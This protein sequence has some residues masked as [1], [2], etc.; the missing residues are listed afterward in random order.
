M[1]SG[2]SKISARLIAAL[3][4]MTVL[5]GGA[6]VYIGIN[7]GPVIAA[8][9]TIA[10]AFVCLLIGRG[11]ARSISGPLKR[12]SGQLEKIADGESIQ[13]IDETEYTGE[14]QYIAGNLNRVTAAMDRL[15]TD[16]D[17]L[18]D[19]A[20]HGDFSYRIDESAHRGRYRSLVNGINEIIDTFVS[21]FDT[22]PSPIMVIDQAYTIRYMNA[23]GANA[24]GRPQE[25]L[26][27]MKCY[28]VFCT[29]DC[30]TD[31]CA[32]MQAM[33]DRAQREH[34]TT[35]HPG[36]SDMEI[37][38]MGTPILYDGEVVGAFEAVV[39]LTDIKA[40]QKT[41]QEQAEMLTA[42]LADVDTA[43]EQVSAG[44]RQVSDGSQAISQGATEQAG[45]VQE[46]SATITEIAEQTK[47][48]AASAGEANRLTVSAKDDADQGSARMQEMQGAMAEI[49]EAAEGISKIIKVIDDIAFQTNILALNAAVEA[50]RA[51]THGKGFAV[52]AE[53]VRNLAARSANAA[54]ETTALIEGSIKKTE[55]GTQIADETAQALANI[56]SGVETAAQLVGEI[57]AASEEQAGAITQ[58]NGG[59]EQVSQVVQTN[60]ATSEEAAAAAEELS[61]QA[62]MLN[63]MVGQFKLKSGSAGGKNAKKVEFP[64]EHAPVQQ[65]ES[66][67][68]LNDED[69]GKY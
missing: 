9:L 53:E 39:D 4:G 61:S 36:G 63:T 59:M 12:L 23:T 28:D 3:A 66:Q 50:A 26:I 40:A 38:Y 57:A 69:F 58:V 22:I 19:A 17:K 42:L 8:A 48:N 55:A 21:D 62:E 29:D 67:I 5:A 37:R 45:S 2:N 24:L 27:G 31:N 43:A 14:F 52:V 32:C 30:N 25:E 20:M 18:G 56:V 60:S 54:K 13:D 51:G 7:R 41:A 35:A 68:A 49:N 33:R 16:T 6:G 34:E 15:F 64:A 10:A 46:L 1:T 47:K 11:L 44:A 65:E